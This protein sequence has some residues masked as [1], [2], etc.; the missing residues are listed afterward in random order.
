MNKPPPASARTDVGTLHGLAAWWPW[1]IL[2]PAS[3]ALFWYQAPVGASAD[4]PLNWD[5]AGHLLR[6]QDFQLALE[7]GDPGRLIDGL[8]ACYVYPPL[9]H[10]ALGTWLA[11]WGTGPFAT[12][13]FMW[14]T[15]VTALLG[16]HAGFSTVASRWREVVFLTVGLLVLG[17][18]Q[19]AAL[20]HA[21]MLDAPAA[22]LAVL[23][24]GLLARWYARP[25]PRRA[26]LVAGAMAAT[27]LTKYNIG[28]P[29]VVSAGALAVLAAAGRDRRRALVLAGIGAAVVAVW[30]AYLS[31]QHDGWYAFREFS[32][33]RSNSAGM[34]VL[35]RAVAYLRIYA[36]VHFRSAPEAIPILLLALAGVR[37]WRHP[38]WLASAAYVGATLAVISDHSYLLDRL[39][40]AGGVV[41]VVPA[42][43]GLLALL[44]MLARGGRRAAHVGGWS[45]VVA[46][47]LFVL[48]NDPACRHQLALLYPPQNPRLAPVSAYVQEV[49][50]SGER[51]RIVG[52]FNNFSEYWARI[53]WRRSGSSAAT[54]PLETE[55][56]YPF[57]RERTGLKAADDPIYAAALA[58]QLADS[59]AAV[60]IALEPAP[61]S[62][63]RDGDYALWNAWKLNYLRALRASPLVWEETGRDF[64]AAGLRVDIFRRVDDA[65]RYVAGWGP[66]EAWGRWAVDEE[67]TLRVA[68][69]ATARHLVIRAATFGSQT[70]P[71]TCRVLCAGEL[72]GAF[73]T[74]GPP[75]RVADYVVDLPA[76]RAGAWDLTLTFSGRWRAGED[77]PRRLAMPVQ[78]IRVR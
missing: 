66:P 7:T 1:L 33:N 2:L 54:G 25:S 36:D 26:V 41:F 3:L 21:T 5:M 50:S 56:G 44:E 28:L 47:G 57:P 12:G 34:T 19:F 71:Q 77:D 58:R 15:W 38:F 68:G 51:V 45:A 53:L 35:Q 67:A 48:G 8:R 70:E 23:S 52:T 49:M 18:A 60:I 20:A 75:W 4:V 9:Y 78:S 76:A 13:V 43:F 40:L 65:V 30:V 37:R 27:V 17:L 69:D 32:R 39:A 11:L 22:A 24:L 10:L 29:L 61:D 73:T 42:G 63:W 6:S 14:L 62:P 72:I 59:R 64:P 16:L 31:W 46:A 55:F 74:G